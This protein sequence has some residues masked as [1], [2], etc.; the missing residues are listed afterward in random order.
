M[1][2]A[3]QPPLPDPNATDTASHPLAAWAKA[4]RRR[5]TETAVEGLRFAFYWRVSTARTIRIR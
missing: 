4:R 5:V 1:S 2:P 3:F